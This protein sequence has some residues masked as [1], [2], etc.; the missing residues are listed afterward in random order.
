MME[1]LIEN[2]KNQQ[3][4][5]KSGNTPG[6]D[7]IVP[8]SAPFLL[9][10]RCF[11][12][13]EPAVL[14][15]YYSKVYQS[16]K[17]TIENPTFFCQSCWE[18]KNKRNEINAMRGGIEGVYCITFKRIGQTDPKTLACLYLSKKNKE[19]NQMANK[20][21]RKMVYRIHYLNLPKKNKNA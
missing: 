12:C 14:I 21:W 11:F 6:R 7:A 15:G 13:N 8:R 1:Q 16:G 9:E 20:V 2:K 19:I 5:G 18:N 10:F 4:R 3:I 17:D